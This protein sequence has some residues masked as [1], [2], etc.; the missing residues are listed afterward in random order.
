MGGGAG[1]PP[2]VTSLVARLAGLLG[3]VA[4]WL[5][6]L[7]LFLRSEVSVRRKLAWS[8]F[9]LLVGSG[10]GF[11]LPPAQL[12]R[13]YLLLL[14][15]LPVLAVA[16]GLLLRSRHGWSFWVGACGFEVCTVFA[17][18]GAARCLFDLAGIRPLLER[19]G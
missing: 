7:R 19:A 13:D 9:L 6:G 5:A 11:V 17:M 3:S 16:D 14:A 4:L 18:A 1:A 12:W 10:V 8:A 15:L 2:I